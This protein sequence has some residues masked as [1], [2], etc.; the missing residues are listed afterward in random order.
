MTLVT[1]GRSREA[2]DGLVQLTM[3]DPDRLEYQLAL[4]RVLAAAPDDR[5]RD[6]RRA[7]QIIDEH[8]RQQRAMDVGETI[9]MA[10]AALGE[11]QQAVGIQRGVL[12]AAER[13]GKMAAAAR[14]KENLKLYER[15]QPCR[16]PWPDDQSVMTDQNP[17]SQI[18]DSPR[19]PDARAGT[20]R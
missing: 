4:A 16:Q 8:F 1:L 6:P 3:R 14:M 12:S 10:L 7:L 20:T 5:V 13:G 15:G 17:G 2:R 11:F 9:A 19:V 18:S